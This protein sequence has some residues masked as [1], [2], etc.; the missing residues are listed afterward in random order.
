MQ[1]YAC[2]AD[3]RGAAADFRAVRAGGTGRT[4]ILAHHIVQSFAPNEV[5][6]EQ[7]LQIGEELCDRFLQGN[8]QYVLAVHND[9]QHLHCHIIFNNTNLYN[10]LSFTYEHNQGKV[11]DRSWAQLRTISDEL[12]KEHGISVIE[13]KTKGVSHFERDMQIQGKS[14]KDKLRAKIAEVAFYSKDFADFLR[15]CSASGIEYVYKPQNKVKLKFRLSG[16]GQQKFTRADTLGEEYTAERIAEQIEQIQKAQAVME[17]LAEKKKPE[18]IVAPPKPAV[19]PKTE[20]TATVITPTK[21]TEHGHLISDLIRSKM[22]ERG[23]SQSPAPTQPTT[24]NEPERNLSVMT[25]EEYIKILN[26]QDT[27]AQVEKAAPPADPW[28]EIRGMGRANEI[29]ADLESGGVTSYHVL[30]SFFY[31]G[32][33]PDDHTDELAELK[34]KYTAI[35]TLI[36]KMKHRDELAPVYKEYKSKS[37]WGQSRFRKKNATTIEEYEQTVKYIKEHRHP[38]LVDGKP[39]TMLDLLEK[40][41]KLKS[42]YNSLLPEHTAFVTK[43]DTAKKYV[44]QVRNYMNEEHNRR[45]REKYRQKKLTQQR[46]KNYLE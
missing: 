13:P 12:C 1:S 22:Q 16:E 14:W 34:K 28:A 25:E 18:K 19:T 33:H 37:G 3:S 36:A 4:Q 2:R 5:T 23:I 35:D 10:G 7:A 8:Y 21:P 46:N 38:Y 31:K 9:K 26:E 39:P 32:G 41:N 45:E 30:A 6:P 20:P 40:S 43:R 42:K 24:K 44:R 15:N 11:K 27:Q 29:I 17:R